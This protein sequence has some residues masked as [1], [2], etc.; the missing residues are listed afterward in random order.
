MI[1]ADH[2]I[3]YPDLPFPPYSLIPL[4]PRA[5]SNLFLKSHNVLASTTFCGSEFHTFTTLGEEISPHLSP[6]HFTPYLQTMTPS[7][8]LPHHQDILSESTLS[9]TVTIL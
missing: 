4:A 2:Q 8:G 9:N 3:Q 1:M 7:S 5:M 6:N